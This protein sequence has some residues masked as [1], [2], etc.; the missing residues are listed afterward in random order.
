[1]SNT[2]SSR[3]RSKNRINHGSARGDPVQ[4]RVKAISIKIGG[5]QVLPLNGGTGGR[6]GTRRNFHF[7]FLSRPRE[8]AISTCATE[9]VITTHLSQRICMQYGSRNLPDLD[10][11]ALLCARPPTGKKIAPSS[12]A[13]LQAIWFSQL[14]MLI[15][16]LTPVETKIHFHHNNTHNFHILGMQRRQRTTH[17]TREGATWRLRAAG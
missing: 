5:R 10:Q 16:L 14:A 2:R 7:F 17:L 11:D 9:G 8:M 1:M 12:S 13:H 6:T 3:I 4:A 15:T